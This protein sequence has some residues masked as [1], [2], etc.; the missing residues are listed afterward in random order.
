MRQRQIS[1]LGMALFL[2]LWAGTAQAKNQY[3]PQQTPL[4]PEQL[5]LIEKS[6]AREKVAIQEIQKHAPLV[7]TYIQTMHPDSELDAPAPVSD[8]YMLSRV[9]FG[10]VFTADAYESKDQGK[11][12]KGSVKSIESLTRLFQLTFS[13]DGFMEMMFVDPSGYDLT[14]Y[15]FS[16]VRREFLGNV[17]TVVFEVRPKPGYGSGRFLGR[18]WVEDQDGNVVR[19][20]GSYR[21]T[22]YKQDAH[23]WVHF[24]S[25]RSNLEPGVWLPAAVYAEEED[26]PDSTKAQGFRAQ[27]YFWGYSLNLPTHAS[28]NETVAID[29]VID[30]SQETQDLSPLQAQRAWNAQAEQN[31]LD[32]LVEAGLL[33]PPSPFDKVLE[34]ITNN[35]IIGNKLLLSGDIHCRVLLTTP[36]ETASIGNTILVSKGLIDVLPS[37]ADLAAVLSFELAQIALGHEI[38]TRYAFDDRLMFPNEATFQRIKLSHSDRDDAA[39]AQEAIKLLNNSVYQSKLGEV[40]VFL[41][42]IQTQEKTLKAL[43][44]PELGDSMLDSQGAPWLLGVSKVPARIETNNLAQIAALPLGSHLKIDPWDDKVEY[45]Q[46]TPAPILTAN[47]KMPLE[48]TPIYFRLRRYGSSETST[49]ASDPKP[50]ANTSTGNASSDANGVSPPRPDR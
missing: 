10:K 9:D 12:F 7:Q 5:A 15:D 48:V 22:P 47:E 24:D 25:W 45:M 8:E 14:H 38:D 21:R 6:I 13:R 26:R 35:L 2:F 19:F 1:I 27:S 29:N 32:R 28:D 42:E 3:L 4:T 50:S 23:Y 44:T 31:V 39:S 41:A 33:A 11:F 20:N 30:Q 43:M 46:T 16:F 34:Q 18:I 17:R 37:E 49:G 40:A 36:L